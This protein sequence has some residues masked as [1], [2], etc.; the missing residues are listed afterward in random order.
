MYYEVKAS[1]TMEYFIDVKA[2]SEE[3]AIKK[4][5]TGGH[6]DKRIFCG[7]LSGFKIDKITKRHGDF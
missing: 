7:G 1:E 6:P 2:D 3:E 4:V 5:K